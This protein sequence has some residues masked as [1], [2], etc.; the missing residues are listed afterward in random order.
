MASKKWLLGACGALLLGSASAAQAGLMIDFRLASVWKE[1]TS[2]AVADRL[3][4]PADKKTYTLDLVANPAQLGHTTFQFD[5]FAVVKGADNDST[6]EGFQSVIGN[7]V[8]SGAVKN[9][10]AP[11]AWGSGVT[12]KL[13]GFAP[14]N[15]NGAQNGPATADPPFMGSALPNNELGTGD[16]IAIR[17]NGVTNYPWIL[18]GDG[19]PTIA[20]TAHWLG[21]GADGAGIQTKIG[22]ARWTPTA[23]EN[24]VIEFNWAKRLTLAGGT[25]ASAATWVED[26][27]TLTKQLNA[28]TGQFSIGTPAAINV[29]VPE[30]ASLSLLA[31]GA[32]G[33]LARRRK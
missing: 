5:I 23:A 19:L 18:D 26:D 1:P 6:N 15:G 20:D 30:P 4:V 27:A 9:I 13:V 8:S 21:N 22:S 10:G 16:Y 25:A 28:L 11:V 29:I 17:A 7:I 12:T 24:G 31:F 3:A 14:F 32:L 2:T 33:L